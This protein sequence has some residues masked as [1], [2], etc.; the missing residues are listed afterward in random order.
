MKK[1]VTSLPDTASEKGIADPRLTGLMAFHRQRKQDSRDKL[2]TAAIERFCERGYFSVSID[3]IASAAG[4]SRV[5][6]YRHFSSKA[7]LTAEV[8]WDA[9][10]ATKP[11]YLAIGAGRFED[12]P[13]VRQW[14]AAIFE[15]DLANRRML[16]VFTQATTDEGTF[17]PRAQALISEL[18]AG[19]GLTI[20]AFDLDPARP[21]DR[22]RWH[23]AWLLLY[24]LLDQSNHAALGAGFATS[25]DVID[26]LTDRFLRFVA[27]GHTS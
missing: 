14:I 12:P 20:P 21:A 11:L 24:E 17:T 22:R 27:A 16:R 3:E 10:E 25:S 23:E 8:F 2:L 9:A 19:L 13:V 5:T 26:I 4:V 6:F 1:D 18:I 15:A 7:A